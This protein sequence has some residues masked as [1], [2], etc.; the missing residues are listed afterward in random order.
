MKKFLFFIILIL[1]I[2]LV[3]C[4]TEPKITHPEYISQEKCN[5]PVW[6]VGDSWRYRYS[7]KSEW[8]YTVERIERDFYIVEDKY[9]VYKPCIDKRT[10]GTVTYINPEGKKMA[11]PPNIYY[12]DF[13]LYVGKKWRKMVSGIPQ[14]GSTEINYLNEFQVTSFEDITVP[15]GTFKAFK[16]ELKQ[17]NYG[18]TFA[19]GKV[20]FW[21]SPEV[22]FVTKLIYE[23]TSYWLGFKSFEL[24]SFKLA[25]NRPITPGAKS[26]TEKVEP[27]TKP[28]V[29]S[30]EKAKSP[31]PVVPS[32][33]TNIVTVT[34]T[35]ANI[36]SGSGN[37]FPITTT[38]KQ[39]DKLI[40]L[41]EKGD[42][43]NVRLENGQEGWINNKFVK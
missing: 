3:N 7:D 17:T 32:Q 40:L 2:S 18:G 10:L 4:A 27:T 1:L 5:A 16:I 24:I 41:G 25:D 34:G 22:K 21:Y 12:F 36:R 42:W 14:R 39:G 19:S 23:G 20:Y 13:P 31:I 11:L 15:A 28:Q 8:Q 43:F 30:P 29:I 9:G 37:E 6:N 35:S 26:S 38:V 33:G